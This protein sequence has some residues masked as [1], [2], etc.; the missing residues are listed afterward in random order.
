MKETMGFLGLLDDKDKDIKLDNNIASC[1]TSSGGKRVRNEQRISDRATK[2][3]A[4][5]M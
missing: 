1:S 4:I 2:H 3:A 5:G